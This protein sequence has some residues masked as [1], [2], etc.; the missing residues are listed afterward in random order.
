M[1]RRTLSVVSG[2]IVASHKNEVILN[3]VF[4]IFFQYL[5]CFLSWTRSILGRQSVNPFNRYFFTFPVTLIRRPSI[6][7]KQSR[8]FEQSPTKKNSQTF[9]SHLITYQ[10]HAIRITRKKHL[11]ERSLCSNA[12]CQR[13]KTCSKNQEVC[14]IFGTCWCRFLALYVPPMNPS[15]SRFLKTASLFIFVHDFICYLPNPPPFRLSPWNF[16]R[17]H[18]HQQ[19]VVL[20]PAKS[21]FPPKSADKK[22]SMCQHH[23]TLQ[24]FRARH[25]ILQ[26]R[27]HRVVETGAL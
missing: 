13:T 26:E 16:F 22:P 5:R 20:C 21:E 3:L 6:S 27:S 8:L 1:T 2:E 4:T 25:K 19:R 14:W 23:L 18:V 24:K 7:R 17:S 11:C 12:G 9:I 15:H 10:V